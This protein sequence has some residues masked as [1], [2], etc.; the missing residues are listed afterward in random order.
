MVPSVTGQ[1]DVDHE[2][3]QSPLKRIPNLPT[4]S[5]RDLLDLGIRQVQELVGRCPEALYAD[6]VERRGPLSSERLAALRMAVYFA[7]TPDP[8]PARLLPWSWRD[9]PLGH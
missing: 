2:A 8:D 9:G 4:D 7:E 3:L 1:R 5:V 6:L